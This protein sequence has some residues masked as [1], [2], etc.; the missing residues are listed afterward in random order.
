M[1]AKPHPPARLPGGTIALTNAP[2]PHAAG[3]ARSFDVA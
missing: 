1:F 2:P 3:I